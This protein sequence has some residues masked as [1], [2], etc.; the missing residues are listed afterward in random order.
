MVLFLYREKSWPVI[1]AHE[2]QDAIQVARRDRGRF[3][4]SRHKVPIRQ[5]RLRHFLHWQDMG[6]VAGLDRADRHAVEFRLGRFL[7]ERDAAGAEDRA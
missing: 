7:Y 3:V 4:A 5:Q 2:H 1:G 6:G